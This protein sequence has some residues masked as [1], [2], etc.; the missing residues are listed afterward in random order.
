MAMKI[1]FALLALVP[2]LALAAPSYEQIQK[3]MRSLQTQS[4]GWASYSIYGKSV[5]GRELG[6]LRLANPERTTGKRPTVIITGVTHGDEYLG[7]EDLLPRWILEHKDEGGLQKWFAN[8]GVII[9]VPVVNPDGFEANT[10]E[11]ANGIDINRDFDVIPTGDKKF[12]QPES[13]MLAQ[14]IEAQLHLDNAKLLMTMDYHCCADKILIPWSYTKRPLS[15]AEIKRHQVIEKSM[16]S[17]FGSH[18]SIGNT[19]GSLGYTGQ[20]TSKDYY[21]AKY[22]SIA[23]TFEGNAHGESLGKHSR[24]WNEVLVTLLGN[25]RPTEAAAPI[26]LL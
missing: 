4:N 19:S 9:F 2:T 11:N 23:F 7:V 8:Q 5:E 22:N 12:T 3:E 24:F 13:R 17:I 10:R 15:A 6:M 16:H 1:L 21:Y 26:T 14:Q 25:A 18:F 20:G